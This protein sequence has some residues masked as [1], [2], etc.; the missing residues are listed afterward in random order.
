MCKLVGS[1]VRPDEI[2]MLQGMKLVNYSIEEIVK[3]EDGVETT[4]YTY[5]QDRLQVDATSEDVTTCIAAG[6]KRVH[7]EN[8]RIALSSMTTVSSAGNEFY[9]NPESRLDI[10]DAVTE[11]MCQGADDLYETDWKMVGGVVKVTIGELKEVKSL[12]LRQKA[13]IVGVQG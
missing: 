3:V 2:E 11:A 9:T 10:S 5:W 4:A 6:E 7:D 8:K 12:A 1:G 13:A